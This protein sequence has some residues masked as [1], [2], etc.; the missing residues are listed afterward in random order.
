MVR[1][2]FAKVRF[3]LKKKKTK[4]N[5]IDPSMALSNAAILKLLH[6]ELPAGINLPPQELEMKIIEDI[7]NAGVMNKEIDLILQETNL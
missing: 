2:I 7:R 5:Y 1:F 4:I 6:N 3:F